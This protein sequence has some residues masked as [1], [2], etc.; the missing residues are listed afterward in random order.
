MEKETW[1]QTLKEQAGKIDVILKEE[2]LEKFYSYMEL[3]K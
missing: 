2:Q 1:K 3:L